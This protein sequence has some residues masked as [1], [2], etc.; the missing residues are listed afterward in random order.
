MANN[1]FASLTV[2]DFPFDKEVV[3]LDSNTPLDKAFKILADNHI[4]AAPVFD[5]AKNQYL[6]FFDV[7]DMLEYIVDMVHH[8]STAEHGKTTLN[9]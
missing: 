1:F 6:G 2:K 7:S 3:T 5:K 9:S 8:H 4:S